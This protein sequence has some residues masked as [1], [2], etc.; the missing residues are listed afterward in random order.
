MPAIARSVP[1]EAPPDH[2]V[3]GSALRLPDSV[4]LRRT[5]ME[6]RGNKA[7]VTPLKFGDSVCEPFAYDRGHNTFDPERTV[8]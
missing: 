2:G 4:S 8:S 3:A 6:L 7:L 5:G 1:A